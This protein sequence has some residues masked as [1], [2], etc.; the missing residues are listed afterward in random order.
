MVFISM[1][2]IV[3]IYTQPAKSI[4]CCSYITVFR[5]SEVSAQLSKQKWSVLNA[6]NS[7]ILFV[8]FLKTNSYFL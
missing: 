6:N 5:N 2:V 4:C 3:L 7:Y 1:I 8:L